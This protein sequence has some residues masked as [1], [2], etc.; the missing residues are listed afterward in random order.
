MKHKHK[1][2]PQNKENITDLTAQHST[3][4]NVILESHVGGIKSIDIQSMEDMTSYYCQII[5]D[6]LEDINTNIGQ[7]A[8]V[9]SRVDSGQ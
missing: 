7:T 6:H 1:Y 8:C 3:N 5:A 4:D 9:D 2:S